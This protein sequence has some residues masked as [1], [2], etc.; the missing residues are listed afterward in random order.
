MTGSLDRIRGA[1]KKRNKGNEDL[2][3]AGMGEEN[4][5]SKINS[6]SITFEALS[7]FYDCSLKFFKRRRGSLDCT[8]VSLLQP[9]LRVIDR[10]TIKLATR[11]V[12]GGVIISNLT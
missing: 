1:K 4:L 7:W 8:R 2:G 11:H 5:I 3:R 10:T 12:G 9:R 6:C